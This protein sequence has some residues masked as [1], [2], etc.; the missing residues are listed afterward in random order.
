MKSLHHKLALLLGGS[1]VATLV[2]MALFELRARRQALEGE[3]RY[4][5][6]NLAQAVSEASSQALTSGELTQL[7]DYLE[8]LGQKSSQISSIRLW[9][10]ASQSRDALVAEYAPLQP[11]PRLESTSYVVFREPIWNATAEGPSVAG[12]IE[13]EISD[14]RLEH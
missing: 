11:R 2:F 14:E 3:L 4:V 9:K 13:I 5:G 12:V 6:R 10:G 7:R 8:N 1:L